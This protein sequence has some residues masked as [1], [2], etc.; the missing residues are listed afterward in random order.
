MKTLYNLFSGLI[1]F[2]AVLNLLLIGRLFHSLSLPAL[3]FIGTQFMGILLGLLNY[4]RIRANKRDWFITIKAIASNGACLILYLLMALQ[5]SSTRSWTVAAIAALLL[6]ASIFWKP[7]Q[8][9]DA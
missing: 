2:V 3:W 1:I 7:S 6:I 8:E 9:V 5:L 4:V